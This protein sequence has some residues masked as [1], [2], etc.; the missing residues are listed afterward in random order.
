MEGWERRLMGGVG[1]ELSMMSHGVKQ[2]LPRTLW[3]RL[4]HREIVTEDL[5]YGVTMRERFA[6]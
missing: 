3:L 5:R 1:I 6:V 4:E 2:G